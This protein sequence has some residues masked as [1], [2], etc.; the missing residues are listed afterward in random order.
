[1]IRGIDCRRAST[2]PI[3]LILTAR[4]RWHSKSKSNA[5]C[6]GGHNRA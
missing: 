1:M 3:A 4:D 5:F 6:T 2:V